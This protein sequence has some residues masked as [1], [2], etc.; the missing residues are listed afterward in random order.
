[1]NCMS[2]TCIGHACE[3]AFTALRSAPYG[4]E[5]DTGLREKDIVNEIPMLI[6]DKRDSG[7]YQKRN[8][9]DL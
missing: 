9:H 7:W 2:H 8:P 3:S 5:T 4:V 1:M 6:W